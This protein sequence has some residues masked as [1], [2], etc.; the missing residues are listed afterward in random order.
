MVRKGVYKLEKQEL[1]SIIVPVYK[2]ETYIKRCIDSL[3][4]QTYANIEIILVD[5]G[6]PDNSGK[7]CDE[8][9]NKDG[10]IK[11]IHKENGGVSSTRNVAISK[12]TGK[13]IVFVDS[14]DWLETNAIESLYKTLIT[15]NVDMVRGHYFINT[16]ETENIATFNQI[17]QERKKIFTDTD[18][19]KNV[20]LR[21]FLEGNIP[22]Y[23]WLFIMK[24][25]LIV[26]EKPFKEDI[27]LAEDLLLLIEIFSR[28]KS[29][30][31]Y[32]MPLYHYYM[33]D[34]GLTRASAYYQKNIKNMPMLTEYFEEVIT[35]SWN[36]SKLVEIR[37][38]ATVK[39]IM[40]YVYA[41]YKQTEKKEFKTLLFQIFEDKNVI[42]LL[43]TSDLKL[44]DIG[45][46][47]Y[48]EIVFLKLLINKK[49][50]LLISLY[51]IRKML[52]M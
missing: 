18:E 12:S 1:I 39:T 27:S 8:Y 50:N 40:S 29:I 43:K 36:D 15:E 47:K 9:A 42:E 2:A 14:D 4:S 21:S 10:R 26:G 6:S 35:Q 44:L 48:L 24:R 45:L 37:K 33:N 49:Y 51:S 32:D 20:I 41:L 23:L 5:D 19:F 46:K 16:D 22:G 11:V 52:K 28:A 17:V 7:I 25:D 31:F 13:Y 30:Y 38:A 3:I 34:S